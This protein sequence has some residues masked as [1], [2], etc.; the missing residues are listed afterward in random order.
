MD[1]DGDLADD[2]ADPG[3]HTDGNASNDTCDPTDDDEENDPACGNGLVD[4]S[5]ECDDGNLVN[6][7]GWTSQC[8]VEFVVDGTQ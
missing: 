6:G 2:C 5:E 1:N 8:G 7:D 3:C 4:G